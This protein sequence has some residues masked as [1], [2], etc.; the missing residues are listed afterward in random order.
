MTIFRIDLRLAPAAESLAELKGWPTT[1]FTTDF[2]VA[3]SGTAQFEFENHLAGVLPSQNQLQM[4]AREPKVPAHFKSQ[5]PDYI[6]GFAF[7]LAT[8]ALKIKQ[9]ANTKASARFL[10]EPLELHLSRANKPQITIG[11]YSDGKAVTQAEIP[12]ALAL[13]E[14]GRALQDFV[15]QLLNL[16]PRLAEHEEVARLREMIAQIV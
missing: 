6:A 4:V 7:N 5:L 13:A 14:I 15:V 1:K 12:I 9:S 16:N 10:D 11:L 3:A 2:A 8:A